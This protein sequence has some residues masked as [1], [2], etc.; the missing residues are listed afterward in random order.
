MQISQP[1]PPILAARLIFETLTSISSPPAESLLKRGA[2]VTVESEK[3]VDVEEFEDASV[4]QLQD[5]SDDPRRKAASWEVHGVRPPHESRSRRLR[6]VSQAST[7]ER[8]EDQRGERRSPH[9]W[10][11]VAKR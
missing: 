11:G 7:G 3:N 10:P 8:E 2:V 5:A 4:H 1:K 6:G 9:A